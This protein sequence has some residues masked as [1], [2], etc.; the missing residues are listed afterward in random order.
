MSSSLLSK[1]IKIK[2]YSTIVL[3]VVLYVCNTWLLMLREERGL[4]VSEKRICG[5]KLDEITG[6]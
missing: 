4:K 3:P 6:E 5:P 1:G 2:I